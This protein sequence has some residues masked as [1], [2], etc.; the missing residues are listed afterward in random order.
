VVIQVIFPR[1]KPF[2][3]GA[4]NKNNIYICT[5]LVKSNMMHPFSI[6]DFRGNDFLK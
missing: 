1:K 3:F 5:R 2:L 4:K 6:K